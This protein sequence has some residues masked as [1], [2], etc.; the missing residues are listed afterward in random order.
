MDE[1]KKMPGTILAF[2]GHYIL[3]DKV[4]NKFKPYKE[5]LKKSDALYIDQA[6]YKFLPT[7]TSG[8]FYPTG[9]LNGLKETKKKFLDICPHADDFWL[10]YIC[11]I[12]KY[13]AKRI[14]TKN[15]HFILMSKGESLFDINVEGG[16]N[17]IQF[18]K[19]LDYSPSFYKI[20]KSD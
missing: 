17:D 12:N 20:L 10:K 5:W 2:R 7:G 8:I 16:N 13:K 11:T 6:N 9:S 1:S 3:E 18:N 19:I 4:T 14:G 15:I